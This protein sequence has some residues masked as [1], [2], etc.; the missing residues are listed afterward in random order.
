MFL[1]D[2][3]KEE[4][5]FLPHTSIQTTLIDMQGMIGTPRRSEELQHGVIEYYGMAEA[6]INYH[7]FVGSQNSQIIDQFIVCSWQR[8]SL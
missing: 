6:S 3:M 5:T 8:L 4:Y 1:K 2:G 7:M